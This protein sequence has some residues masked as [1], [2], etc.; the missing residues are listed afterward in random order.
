[1]LELGGSTYASDSSCREGGAR[2]KDSIW[3]EIAEF[4]KLMKNTNLLSSAH[5]TS[6][7]RKNKQ[8]NPHLDAKLWN[9]KNKEEI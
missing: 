5:I 2:E 9:I 1:V 8:Q 6:P 3:G 7:R 4:F